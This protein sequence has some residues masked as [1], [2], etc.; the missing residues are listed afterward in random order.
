MLKMANSCRKIQAVVIRKRD[1]KE[2]LLVHYTPPKSYWETITGN[3]NRNESIEEGL[4]RELMEEIS[5]GGAQLIKTS[6]LSSFEYEK[7][8][9]HYKEDI[10][11][12]EVSSNF[13]PDIGHNP[14]GE[15]NAYGW[16]SSGEALKLV[17]WQEMRDSIVKAL[18]S[19]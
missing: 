3:V 10:F 11:M 4:K 14:D 13:I 15:H 6:Y 8:E 7:N 19:D 12:I 9:N 16:F 17:P 18:S 1:G 5:L 2:V